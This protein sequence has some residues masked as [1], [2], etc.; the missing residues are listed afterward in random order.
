MNESIKKY[1]PD[2]LTGL[3]EILADPKILRTIVFSVDDFKN[4]RVYEDF[5]IW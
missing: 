2:N 4:N 3:T 1:P 5:E